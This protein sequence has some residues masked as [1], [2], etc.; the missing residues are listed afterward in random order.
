MLLKYCKNVIAAQNMLV[1]GVS[2]NG[3]RTLMCYRQGRNLRGGGMG[4]DSPP[5]SRF[6]RAQGK[7]TGQK[8]GI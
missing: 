6:R 2:K 4:G 8:C 5:N 7:F 1:Q 3:N